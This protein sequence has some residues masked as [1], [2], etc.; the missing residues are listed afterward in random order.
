MERIEER[1]VLSVPGEGRPRGGV[2]WS[3]IGI[4]PMEEWARSKL[5]RPWFGS[6]DPVRFEPPEPS[7]ESHMVAP[8][9]SYLNKLRRPWR[10]SRN[11]NRPFFH[12]RFNHICGRSPSFEHCIDNR[13][14]TL[15]R[16]RVLD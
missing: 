14:H 4:I 8:F 13:L 10:N 1:T 12:Q 6:A 7:S 5:N 15:P 16:A 9:P 3:P 11:W 2:T